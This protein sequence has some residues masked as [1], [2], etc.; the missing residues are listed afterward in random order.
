MVCSGPGT[1]RMIAAAMSEETMRVVLQYAA[2]PELSRTLEDLERRDGLSIAVRPPEARPAYEAAMREAEVIW[3]LL[4]PVTAG[5][6]AASPRLRLIQKIGVGVNTVDLEAARGRGIAVCNMP[7]T[8][9][10]AVAEMTLLLMLS[11][12]RRLRALE[13][14][15]RTPAGWMLSPGR[16]DQLG[17]LGG[18]VVGLVGYGAVP[19]RLA[20]VL[21]AM[22][23]TV[24]FTNRSPRPTAVGRAMSLDALLAESDI[25]SLHLPLTPDTAGLIDRAALAT[26]R[27]GAILI[28]TA[29]GGLVDEPAL[30]A[31]LESGHLGG[32]GLDVFA[33]EPTPVDTRLLGSDR[34]VVSPHVAWLT[35]ETLARSLEV[36]TE[37]CRRVRE[38]RPLLHQVA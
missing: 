28:N 6:I 11:V 38:G 35:R 36:A 24:V 31:A 16:Q 20:P 34:V 18:R 8:N 33:E 14:A 3:H 30:V 19:A 25:V 29:R 37:N 12:L 9:T 21:D 15:V 2:G 1:E 10:Q 32:A 13:E 23:A 17:E 5:L 7:G 27:P 4:D 26:M 22:G